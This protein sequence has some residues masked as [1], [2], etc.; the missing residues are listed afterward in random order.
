M[1]RTNDPNSASSQFFIMHADS[2]HL[3]GHYAAF[4]RVISGLA[5]VDRIANLPKDRNDR[6]INPPVMEKVF[7]VQPIDE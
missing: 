2:P 7:F 1:A 4:G 5:E 3:D 6:P